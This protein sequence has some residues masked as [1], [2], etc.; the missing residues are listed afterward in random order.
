MATRFQGNLI[1]IV[2]GWCE[3]TS[4]NIQRICHSLIMHFAGVTQTSF[5]SGPYSTDC[6]PCSPAEPSSYS[7]KRAWCNRFLS[8]YVR[9]SNDTT[10]TGTWMVNGHSAAGPLS[11]DGGGLYVKELP[12][13]EPLISWDSEATLIEG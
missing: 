3:Q 8:T 9:V 2:T 12:S 10:Y 1:L 4:G 11:M 6:H 13:S 5:C 7:K